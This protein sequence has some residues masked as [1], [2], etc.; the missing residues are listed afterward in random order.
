MTT[1][2]MTAATNDAVIFREI[3]ITGEVT[4]MPGETESCDAGAVF[5]A[6]ASLIERAVGV[7]GG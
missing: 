7:N 4:L 5:V 3:G 1:T 6:P 2:V